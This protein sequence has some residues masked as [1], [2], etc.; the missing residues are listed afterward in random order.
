MSKLL[1]SL[2]LA[3]TLGSGGVMY[4]FNAQSQKNP[5]E[6]LDLI[7][8]ASGLQG[9]VVNLMEVERGPRIADLPQISRRMNTTSFS[10]ASPRST[11]QD[12]KEFAQDSPQLQAMLKVDE[13][14]QRKS[15]WSRAR[16]KV[17]GDNDAPRSDRLAAIRE[18][19]KPVGNF[20]GE[21]AS[22]FLRMGPAEVIANSGAIAELIEN[23]GP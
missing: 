22:A 9:R 2:G 4:D 23:G 21:N 17:M 19:N 14:K 12:I 10:S 7:Q 18:R 5:G 11:E 16:Q 6:L 8:Y 1:L 13:A 15:F 3:T 20:E